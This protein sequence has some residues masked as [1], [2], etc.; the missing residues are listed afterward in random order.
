[1]EADH[2]LVG[3]PDHVEVG[4]DVA[5]AVDDHS[6]ADAAT[7]ALALLRGHLTE[8]PVVEVLEA[9]VARERIGA[10]RPLAAQ[11]V[12][13]GDRHHR[14]A[15]PLGHPHERPLHLLG[16]SGPGGAGRGPSQAGQ[17]EPGGEPGRRE[18]DS[19]PDPHGESQE[20]TRPQAREKPSHLGRSGKYT[21]T[22]R[23]GP[24]YIEAVRLMMTLGRRYTHVPVGLLS[25]LL[26]VM[27]IAWLL[28]RRV[29]GI[30]A[31]A[32]RIAGPVPVA[33][34]LAAPVPSGPPAAPVR[35][36]APPPAELV[37]SEP[38]PPVP[39]PEIGRAHV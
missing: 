27:L 1:M 4:Q 5:L 2:D 30:W 17:A 6:G 19:E 23:T 32:L 37:A 22:S 18:P 11:E 31:A 21:L 10:G 24:L 25:V 8:V 9:G 12:G 33:V 26:V 7:A 38:P 3:A 28:E 34:T 20:N 35:P 36:E 15:H 39:A 29:D 14:R 16:A 13:G